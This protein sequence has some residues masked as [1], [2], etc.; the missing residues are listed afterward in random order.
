MQRLSEMQAAFALAV[1][2][3]GAAVPAPVTSHADPR[4]RKRFNVYRN[5]IHASLTNV[6]AGRFPAV[7]RLVGEEF[8]AATARAYIAERP[9]RSP[10][11]MQYG[12]TF[13][14]FLETFEPV[15]DV[16]YLPDVA[17]IEWAW[18]MAYYAADAGPM[19]RETLEHIPPEHIA[20]STV[21]LHPGL[22]VV[23][24]RFPAVTIWTANTGDDEPE[25][26][27][28]GSGG[29][30]AMILR[31]ASHVEVRRLPSGGAVFIEALARGET[32]EAA[33]H[34]TLDEAK[35]FDLQA[36]LAGLFASG[37]IVAVNAA[38]PSSGNGN[39]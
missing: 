30:D 16:P 5:N 17:R 29:E 13:A 22:S 2:H 37:A 27:D 12:E 11:L 1:T 6:L 21:T 25:P 4:P 26:I 38:G 39:L 24:S 8:F 9:P 28:A 19:A 3:A 20:R 31:P 35:D 33:T 18:S 14:A 32:L 34:T 23:R 7:R 15:Q 10:I 36:N